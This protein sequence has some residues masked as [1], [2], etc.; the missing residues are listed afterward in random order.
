MT[1]KDYNSQ[2][3][4]SKTMKKQEFVNP[5]IESA[6]S[7]KEEIKK[8]ETIK[9]NDSKEENKEN[10]IVQ[11]ENLK[12]EVKEDKKEEKI[13]NKKDK[14]KKEI[15]KKEEAVINAKSLPLSTK[16]CASIC[17]FINHKSIDKS[18]EDLEDVLNFKR[19][20]PMKKGFPHKKGKGV[21]AGKYHT[22][23]VIQFIKMLKELKANSNVNGL[24]NPIII[25]AI[26]NRASMP[27][28]RFG[29]IRRKRTHIKIKS[30]DKTK[31]N[32]KDTK[33]E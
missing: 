33:K 19:V 17:R 32:K 13:E 18:I 27:Y 21:M 31:I 12:K 7:K 16:D 25:E 24:E 4:K 28:G 2:Q 15:P 20:I 11:E 8:N 14:Q 3:R 30:R 10:K 23:S 5:K 1:E 9:E 26:A 29:R 6:L 22:K